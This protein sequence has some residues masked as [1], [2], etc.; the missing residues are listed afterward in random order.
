MTQPDQAQISLR[1]AVLDDCDQVYA[2]RN[3][4]ATRQYFLDPSPVAYETHVAWMQKVLAAPDKALLIGEMSSQP[5]GVLRYDF[6]DHTAE[7]SVYID[8]D[9]HGH[10]LGSQLLQAG[11]HW[12]RKHHG[13]VTLLRARVLCENASSARAFE[14]AGYDRKIIV[15][16]QS[17]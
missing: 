14:K 5:F 11:T 10:G 6:S 8:P 9:R 13:D 7:V 4:P 1:K 3:N 15:Y 17:V 2:W 16:E 12:I